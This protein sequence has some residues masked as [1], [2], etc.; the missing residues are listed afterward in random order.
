[1]ECAFKNIKIAIIRKNN[2]VFDKMTCEMIKGNYFNNIIAPYIDIINIE[3]RDDNQILNKIIENIGYV[4]N[5]SY[6]SY[7]CYEDNDKMIYH[8]YVGTDNIGVSENMIGRFLSESHEPII[9]NSALLCYKNMTLIDITFDDVI[10]TIR[11]RLI[12]NAV[13]I[14]TDNT[15]EN[16]EYNE[17]PIENTHLTIN[18]CRC[19]QFD[20]M[21]KVLCLFVQTFDNEHQNDDTQMNK[22]ATILFKQLKIYGDV[23]VSMLTKIPSTEICDLSPDIMKKILCVRSNMGTEKIDACSDKSTRENFYDLINLASDAYGQNICEIIPDDI[24]KMPS[25]NST[26]H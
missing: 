1:M 6:R 8:V 21:S 23:I 19:V 7:K 25:L 3:L 11:S 2:V 14:K 26:L 13:L 16:V 5:D 17:I 12:H 18:N 15:I 22:Y 20:F 10:K 4:S 9:G 24:I